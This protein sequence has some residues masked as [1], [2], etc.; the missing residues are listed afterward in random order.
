[1]IFKR[2]HYIY[3]YNG[4]KNIYMAQKLTKEVFIEKAK[5]KY[6]NKFNF[7]KVEY[8][9]NHTKVCITCPIHGD[10][11]INPS[12]FINGSKYGCPECSGLKQWNTKKFIEIAKEI[13]GNKYDYSK[14]QYVNKRTNVIITCPIH[15]DFIQNPHNH[16]SQHQG[17]P[18]CGKKYAKEWR[19]NQ[20]KDFINESINRFGH[21]YEF[22]N[23]ETLYE[24]S[25][26]KILIKCKKCGNIFEK[27]A[28]DH[29]TSP[30]GGCLHCYANK[31]KAEEEIG[32]FLQ[33]LLNNC[34]ILFRNRSIL[35][36]SEIDIY[37][38]EKKIGIE[39]NGIY[40]HSSANGKTKN[41]HLYKTEECKHNGIGLIQIFEDEFLEHKNIVFSK[42][43]HI[44][45]KDNFEKV[46]ARKCLVREISYADAICFLNKNHIQ[47]GVKATIYL[48]LFY[49]DVLISVMTFI[50]RKNE[51]ELNR[52][53]NDISKQVIGSGGKLFSYFI[54]NYNPQK[55]KSFADRR[56]T[57]NEDHNLYTLLG[58]KFNKYILPDYRYVYKN[59]NKRLHKFNFRKK[60]LAK[61]YNLPL[62]LTE[63]EMAEKIG[64]NK[65]Y[66][67]GL[68]KYIWEKK[69]K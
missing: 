48:G 36:N 40:W 5:K 68:I 14:T 54:K 3:Q 51:W 56:W 57:I 32:V 12:C 22:P 69:T 55:V 7:D 29:L 58:F 35:K 44:F 16:I 19:K 9:N 65:I 23:I 61:K 8:V 59:G 53:A 45:H 41:Y 37:V 30:H 24:N 15:G 6:G 18:E 17:C 13:H 25:H 34:T 28:A 2:K 4:I 1:M 27:I 50:K 63:S 62:S 31:S 26:S 10:F 52:F 47:G 66:D 67:C 33:K 21:I 43:Q 46:Y 60:L 39:Y 64:L 11:W 20:Y 38:P 49:N 42:L